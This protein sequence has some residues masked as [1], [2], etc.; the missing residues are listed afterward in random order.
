MSIAFQQSAQAFYR[1]NCEEHRCGQCDPQRNPQFGD[2]PKD[3][4]DIHNDLGN[5]GLIRSTPES[6]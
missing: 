1:P 5:W 2:F 3:L 6:G 4:F